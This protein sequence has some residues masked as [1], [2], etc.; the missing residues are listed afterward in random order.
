[1]ANDIID[2]TGIFGVHREVTKPGTF[3]VG[4]LRDGSAVKG[5]TCKTNFIVGVDYLFLGSWV[6]DPQWGMQFVFKSF[7]ELK[8]KTR[9]GILSY[10]VP[11][12]KDKCGMGPVRIGRVIDA[13]GV[14]DTMSYLKN[15][16]LGVSRVAGIT[17]VQAMECSR[18]LK[19]KEMFEET[20]MDLR[21]LFHGRGFSDATR[22]ACIDE[23]GVCA[24]VKIRKDPFTMLIRRFPGAGFMR[25]DKLYTNLVLSEK[26]LKRQTVCLIYQLQKIGGSTW[27]DMAKAIVEMGRLIS[28]DINPEKAVELGVR[29][30]RLSQ[31]THNGKKWLAVK[32]DAVSERMVFNYAKGLQTHEGDIK[33]RTEPRDDES[34]EF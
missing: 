19:E 27:I 7:T 2:L 6:D 33:R 16:W 11:I 18:L 23:F 13:I 3:F 5:F 24:P 9:E 14:D 34:G 20:D 31:T 25:C 28:S 17:Q 1:M 21:G 22:K 30:N 32:E 29:A 4:C 26:K 15:E 8:P 12:L 10:T